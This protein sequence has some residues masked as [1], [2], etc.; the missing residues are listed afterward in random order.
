MLVGSEAVSCLVD[1]GISSSKAEAVA[2]GRRMCAAGL[3]AHVVKQHNFA[4]SFLFYRWTEKMELACTTAAKDSGQSLHGNTIVDSEP[5]ASASA[6][7][8]SRPAGRPPAY[9]GQKRAS[10]NLQLLQVGAR[11]VF[12]R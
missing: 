6:V 1:A 11:F 4:D 2:L 3:L 9:W 12:L 5:G 10:L 7:P 8:R